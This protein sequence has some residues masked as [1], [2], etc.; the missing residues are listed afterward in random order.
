MKKILSIV[1]SPNYMGN[2]ATIIDTIH[3]GAKE[4][5]YKTTRL[6]LKDYNLSYCEACMCCSKS[7]Q[8][9]IDD[10]LMDI[11]KMIK[12]CDILVLAS[13]VWHHAVTGL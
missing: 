9:I 1:A 4:K 3:K 10:D 13:P 8:C 5:G 12:E 2:T 7:G 11:I 6:F